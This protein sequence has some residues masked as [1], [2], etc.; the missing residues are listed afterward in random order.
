M[1]LM[2]KFCVLAAV[3]I[4]IAAPSACRAS[5][6]ATIGM[7]GVI[8]PECVVT[9]TSSSVDLGDLTIDGTQTITFQVFCNSP[10]AYEIASQY[11]GLKSVVHTSAPRRFTIFVPYT[12][13]I[14]IPTT[15]GGIADTCSSVH[16]LKRS[17]HCRL[18]NSGNHISAEGP[19]TLTIS[20]SASRDTPL[21][22]TYRDVLTFSVAPRL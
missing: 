16:I 21:A 18:T 15:G 22:G 2:R 3:A 10:F 17:R 12:V 11:G 7:H 13:S 1:A 14:R 4:L 5:D 8:K 19:T 9:A 6:T 20:W